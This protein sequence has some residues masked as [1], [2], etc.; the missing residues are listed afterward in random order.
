M[1][2]FLFYLCENP[3][4]AEMAACR[5]V[6]IE[7]ELDQYIHQ[8]Q[9]FPFLKSPQDAVPG[10]DIRIASS[11]SSGDT[12]AVG[13]EGGRGM[14][15]WVTASGISCVGGNWLSSEA[16]ESCRDKTQEEAPSRP[17]AAPADPVSS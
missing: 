6:S 3:K 1:R 16:P 14:G 4:F 13:D 11:S 15:D 5:E 17:P 8:P 9:A 7:V 2:Y 10:G 12:L